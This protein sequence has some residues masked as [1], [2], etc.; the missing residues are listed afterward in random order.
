MD[1][2]WINAEI[3][4]FCD[5]VGKGLMGQSDFQGRQQAGT[6]CPFLRKRGYRKTGSPEGFLFPSI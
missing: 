2:D 5:S 3:L 1:L 6:E 4:Q